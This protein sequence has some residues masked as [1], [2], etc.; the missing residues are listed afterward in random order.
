VALY[1]RIVDKGR[2]IEGVCDRP[3]PSLYP[4][5]PFDKYF[6]VKGLHCN[7]NNSLKIYYGTDN[8]QD[9]PTGIDTRTN[10][11]GI[12]GYPYTLDSGPT[13]LGVDRNGTVH[14]LYYNKSVYLK[15]GEGLESPILSNGT[16]AIDWF[17]SPFKVGYNVTASITNIGVFNKTDIKN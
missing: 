14:M 8:V 2:V 9:W 16:R 12:Y 6:V 13:I 4:P 5:E 15:V 7:V 3:M 1:E 17:G 11:R 10:R